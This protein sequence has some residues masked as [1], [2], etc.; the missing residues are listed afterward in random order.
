VDEV[1]GEEGLASEPVTFTI[2]SSGAY[3]ISIFYLH[4]GYVMPECLANRVNVYVAG[5]GSDAMAFFV[6]FPLGSATSVAS[7]LAD[8]TAKYGFWGGATPNDVT[9]ANV[10]RIYTFPTNLPSPIVDMVDPKRLAP[11]SA[12]M[13]RGAEGLALASYCARS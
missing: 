4:P 11:Q 5:P 13:P 1:T 12:A 3:F 9:F 10:H 6:S 2:P 7:T 8:Y